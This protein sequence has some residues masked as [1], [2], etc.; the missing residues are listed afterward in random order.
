MHT[1]AFALNSPW[2]CL[3][4][5]S[6][7]HAHYPCVCLCSKR[8]STWIIAS[9]CNLPHHTHKRSDKHTRLNAIHHTLSSILADVSLRFVVCDPQIWA[10]CLLKPHVFLLIHSAAISSSL[11]RNT[12]QK[13]IIK[14]CCCTFTP[15]PH[16]WKNKNNMYEVRK[17]LIFFIFFCTFSAVIILCS[18]NVPG[19]GKVSVLLRTTAQ[20]FDSSISFL[21]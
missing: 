18:R 15:Y 20:N 3:S 12:Q 7:T 6:Q 1:I 5:F 4:I 16:F 14:A 21:Q 11:Q 19:S 8:L 2:F 9:M 17:L 10:A 13:L